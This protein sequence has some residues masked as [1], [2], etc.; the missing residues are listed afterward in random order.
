VAEDCLG[1]D[2][3]RAFS[4]AGYH[5]TAYSHNHLVYYLLHQFRQDIE[6]YK[7]L[8][9]LFLVNA[10]ISDNLFFDD[11]P[12]AVQD[13]FLIRGFHPGLSISLWLSFL[14]QL[15]WRIR[16]RPIAEAYRDEFPR[17]LPESAN[18]GYFTLEDAIDWLK[19]R[20]L[21]APK[22]FLI[23]FHVYPP[24]GPYNTRNQ[25]VD[26]FDDGWTP[27]PKESFPL[28]RG[29]DEQTMNETRRRYDEFIA[30]VDAEFGRLY[31]FMAQNGIL[32]DTH[33]ILTTDH[34]EMFERGV[35]GHET[36]ALYDPIIHIPLIISGPNQ[37]QREDVYSFTSSVD[38]LPT[39]L[40]TA[41]LP[42]PE[43]CEGQIL[44][45][46][47]DQDVDTDRSIFS[48][49]AK[50]NWKYAPLQIGTVALIKD[51]YK[52]IH[53]FGYGGDYTHQ[54]EM[55]DLANDRE[56]LVDMYSSVNPTASNLRHE[57]ERQLRVV[58]QAY[59]RG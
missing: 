2:L 44:P 34:G 18:S 50:R 24:H 48:V 32:D 23:Y 20:L 29:H 51:Q 59:S 3:F 40:H 1:R 30:Y 16:T 49:E 47:G 17:G 45:T 10:E 12:T 39:L 56:E 35:Q 25:F 31:D 11:Y 5:T 26:L 19:E 6:E 9:D 13:E 43:W 46:F 58:N 55:Y 53:H 41:G 8:S 28:G 14:D 21:N 36:P 37:T 22:P 7:R 54:F 38:L 57:L 52:L 27:V 15:V 4:D 33:V 42:V